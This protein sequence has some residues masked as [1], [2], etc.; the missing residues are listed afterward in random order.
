M[1]NDQLA[2]VAAPDLGAALTSTRDVQTIGSQQRSPVAFD[3]HIRGY[4]YG[5][6]S[7]T[8]DGAFWWPVRYDL[9]T[10]LTKIDPWLI[11]DV[12]VIPGPYGLRYGPGFSYINV[13]TYDT[14]RFDCPESHANLGYSLLTNGGQNAGRATAYGGSQDWGYIF[15]YGIRAGADYHPGSDAPLSRIPAQYELQNFL[16]QFGVD[17]GEDARLEL[18]AIRMDGN[19]IE[20][21]AQIFDIDNQAT[22]AY[23]LTYVDPDEC[24]GGDLRVTSWYNRS[25]FNGSFPTPDVPSDKR[26]P[27]FS[28]V[29]RIENALSPS[30]DVALNGLTN[31][32]LTSTGARASRTFGEA[33]ENQVRVGT[34]VSWIE[35]HILE[36]YNATSNGLPYSGDFPFYTN[37]PRADDRS[38]GFRRVDFQLVT[39]RAD[40]DWR[41]CGLGE[42]VRAVLRRPLSRL[43]WLS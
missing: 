21:A 43:R 34:D 39:G 10:M 17:V 40:S 15:S 27:T 25:R 30:G 23:Q 12:E 32:D 5:Q 3:P 16:G 41:A 19:D 35:Q 1:T 28:V 9:D 29:D 6:I 22:D 11:R 8:A 2:F 7:A 33:D 42:Y 31:G 14:L 36:A 4:K 24:Y 18:R 20:Y 13:S 26:L 38:R 37:M